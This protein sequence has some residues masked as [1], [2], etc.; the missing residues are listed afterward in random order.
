MKKMKEFDL[1]IVGGGPGGYVAAIKAAQEKLNVALIEKENIGGVCLNHGCIPTKAILKSAKTFVDFKNAKSFGLSVLDD[2]VS[3]DLDKIIDRK[4]DV[5]KRLTGGVSMLLKKN[6]VTV[7][8]GYGKI[9]NANE[10]IVNEETLKAKNII[11]ATGASPIIPP[12]KGAKESYDKGLLLTSKELLNLKTPPKKMIVIGG[13]IIGI[14]FATIFN[15]FNA[16]VTVI[17][18]ADSIITNMD[19]DIITEYTRKL[20]RDKINI[21]TGATVTE[22]NNNTVTYEKDNKAVNLEADIILM[23]VGVR[24]NI[25]SFENLKLEMKGSGVKVNEFMQTNVPNVYAIG[26]VTGEEMLAHVASKEGL[27]AVEHILGQTN[28][29]NYKYIPKAIYGFPEIATV[30]LT[31]QDAIKQNIDYTVSKFPLLANGKALADGHRVGFIK[32]IKGNELDE[33]LGAHIFAYNAVDLLSEV[34]VAMNAELTN[35][36]LADTIHPHPSLS[37]IIMEAAMKKPIHI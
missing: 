25:D 13:G 20:K 33:I 16:E 19:Q 29:M 10:V 22:I 5:V 18:M 9:K 21:L 7:F 27:I 12:I 26:D 30:G 35:Y 15:S 24:P 17:E 2:A 32:L 1:I 4:D 23:A 28:E 11:I 31:E 6:G 14:E 8:D 3:F 37:E 36:D 34:V